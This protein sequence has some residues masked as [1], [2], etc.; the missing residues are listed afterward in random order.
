M[1]PHTPK[2]E[3]ET[4]LKSKPGSLGQPCQLQTNF[5]VLLD[6]EKMA[7]KAYQYNVI[8]TPNTPK[9]F[10]D[11]VFETFQLK[12][13]KSIKL[14]FDGT[15]IAYSTFNNLIQNQTLNDSVEIVDPRSG[16]LIEYKVS[17]AETNI[18]I[19]LTALA[20]YVNSKEELVT[21]PLVALNCINSVLRSPCLKIGIAV[22]QTFY[23]PPDR[24]MD[25]SVFSELYTG[26]FQSVVLGSKIF[27]NVDIVHKAFTKEVS[28]INVIKQVINPNESLKF[29]QINELNENLQDLTLIYEL[30]GNIARTY[31]F[32][33]FIKET[34]SEKQFKMEDG[35][36]ITIQKYFQTIKGLNLRFPNLPCIEIGSSIRTIFV[37][38]E[39]CRV[40]GGQPIN[41]KLN[42]DQTT[43]MIRHAATF[44]D[45]RKHKIV[46]LVNRIKHNEDSLIKSFGIQINNEFE[47]IN[48][49]VLDSPQLQYSKKVI[50]PREGVWR[51][52][53]V[54][55]IILAIKLYQLGSIKT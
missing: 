44:P 1:T 9:K 17:L 29:Y 36:T 35:R 42:S 16:R 30:P 46:E 41:K 39:F 50:T 8:I 51:N 2:E 54:K 32:F 6:V 43:Q 55:S 40:A 45:I 4:T 34:P 38:A 49:R 15:S 12:M 28:I 13:F 26:L 22:K 33:R 3:P 10:M 23:S 52:V 31:K 25:L 21:K 27:L 37:P 19:D 5:L 18:E 20:K 11:S 24:S 53:L 7:P 47:H 14:S 48:G